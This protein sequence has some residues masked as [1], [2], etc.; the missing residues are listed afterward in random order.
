MLYKTFSSRHTLLLDYMPV[1]NA[2][3]YTSCINTGWHVY[4]CHTIYQRI[5]QSG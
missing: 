5:S 3:S 4:G 2:R 1:R